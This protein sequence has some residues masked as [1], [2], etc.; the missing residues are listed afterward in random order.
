MGGR[1]KRSR[2][3]LEGQVSRKDSGGSGE[4]SLKIQENSGDSGTDLGESKGCRARSW[5]NTLWGVCTEVCAHMHRK[6]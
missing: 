6:S 1:E 4:G 5:K 2:Q 3:R